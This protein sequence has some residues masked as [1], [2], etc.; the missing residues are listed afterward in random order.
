MLRF[1]AWAHAGCSESLGRW[2]GVLL[3]ETGGGALPDELH[4]DYVD[5]DTLTDIRQAA[6][7]SFL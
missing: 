2:L 4:Y 5:V 3:A 1:C 6:R 7:R